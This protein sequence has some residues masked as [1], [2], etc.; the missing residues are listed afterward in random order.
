M[1][2]CQ[3]RSSC[4]VKEEWAGDCLNTSK[5]TV[6]SVADKYC[7][8]EIWN[9]FI[10]W[11]KKIRLCWE[12]QIAQV[13]TATSALTG[14]DDWVLNLWCWWTSWIMNFIQGGGNDQLGVTLGSYRLIKSCSFCASAFVAS[15]FCLLL[16]PAAIH[17]TEQ[18]CG[19]LCSSNAKVSLLLSLLNAQFLLLRTDVCFLLGNCKK[20]WNVMELLSFT[21]FVCAP[22]DDVLYTVKKQSVKSSPTKSA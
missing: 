18:V 12:H 7:R 6:G 8:K 9:F 20:L 10:L 5:H 1:V 22:D 4:T 13:F 14:E 15:S 2:E 21:V 17:C 19:F 3:T 16:W 11:A